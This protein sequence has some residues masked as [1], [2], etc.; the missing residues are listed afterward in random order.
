[1]IKIKRFHLSLK[2]FWQSFL[3]LFLAIILTSSAHAAPPDSVLD[4]LYAVGA[5]YYNP[6]GS[7]A[8]IGCYS[9]DLTIAGSTAEEKIW[10]GLT[11]FMTPEQAAG[12]MGNMAHE[13]NYFNPLQHE[14]SQMNKYWG[15]GFDLAH[16]SSKAYGLGLAQW[17]FGRRVAMLQMVQQQN[18]S[19]MEYFTHPETYSVGYSINGNKL[20]SMIGEQAY[21]ALIAVE[22]EYLRYEL[23]TYRSSYGGLFDQT[24][25]QGAA[26]F[27]LD[28]FERPANPELSR[29][30]RRA[31]AQKYYDQFNGSILTPSTSA[32][33]GGNLDINA[34]ALE[35][36][37]PTRNN[38]L[39][40]T[41]QYTAALDAVGLSSYAYDEWVRMGASCDAFVATVMRYSGVDPDFYCCGVG[42]SSRG[43]YQYLIS[44]PEKYQLIGYGDDT[45]IVQP[46]D[47][48]IYQNHHIELVVQQ[49]DGTYAIASASHAERTA[50]VSS[51][52]Y[53]DGN[54]E[55]FRFI[56]GTN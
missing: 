20:I 52:V 45:S 13:G 30:V 28:R 32:C 24:T 44:H 7:N 2:V 15:S 23:E 51:G 33:I 37:W 50:S 11:S 56:G 39:I 26:D 38:T 18:P 36:A 10:S 5:H 12:V 42:N 35:L 14:V 19:L 21:D 53:A 4:E 22:L 49:S 46:G 55:I 17:S 1:M 6:T 43:I 34:T 29:A 47:I 25:V 54:Y 9:G 16:D 3:C 40:A 41:P 31:D 48:R 8:K 27:F